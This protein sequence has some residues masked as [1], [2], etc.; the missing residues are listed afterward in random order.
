[1]KRKRISLFT[2]IAI[3]TMVSLY[4][5]DNKPLTSFYDSNLI[6]IDYHTFGGIGLSVN[7]LATSIEMGISPEFTNVL[8]TFDDSKQAMERYKSKNLV[9]NIL[10]FSGLGA[11]LGGLYYPLLSSSNSSSTLSNDTLKT[12]ICVALGGFVAELIGAFVLPSS[13]QDIFNSVKM[14]NRDK[15]ATYNN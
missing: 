7:G 1:M 10:L 2:A 5:E 8:S 11:E 15:I 12:G 13:Y 3:L 9:G 4:S 14:Y 6:K